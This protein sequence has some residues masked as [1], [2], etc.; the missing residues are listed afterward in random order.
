VL[1]APEVVGEGSTRLPGERGKV[2]YKD[3]NMRRL[4]ARLWFRERRARLLSGASCQVCGTTENLELHHLDRSRKR[5]HKLA[6][7]TATFVA[8]EL[9]VCT[10][11]CAEH[12]REETLRSGAAYAGAKLTPA[13]VVAIRAAAGQVPVSELAD[14]YGVGNKTIADVIH[15]RTWKVLPDE[16]Q[17]VAA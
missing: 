5:T 7:R 9:K 4:Y 15:W 13:D 8:D 1:V 14:R 12:H 11:L 6:S 3:P 10:W 17:A 2:P 16:E